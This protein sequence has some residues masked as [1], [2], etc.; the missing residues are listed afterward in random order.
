[1][2]L[3]L[4]FCEVFF[5]LL[6]PQNLFFVRLKRPHVVMD[7]PLGTRTPDVGM[8]EQVRNIAN[9]CLATWG[10]KASRERFV[11]EALSGSPL[12]TDGTRTKAK[13]TGT[14]RGEEKSQGS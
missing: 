12:F 3:L 7:Q 2:E 4:S 14:R 1:M 5:H 10:G 6:L 13:K 8:L 11:G 9:E